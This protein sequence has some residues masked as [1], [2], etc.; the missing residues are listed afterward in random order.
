MGSVYASGSKGEAEGVSVYADGK[1]IWRGWTYPTLGYVHINIDKPVSAKAITIKM[2][3]NTKTQKATGD[4]AELAGGKADTFQ[5][6][7]TAKGK[8]ELRIVD[9]DFLYGMMENSTR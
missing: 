7:P 3:G 8:T 1:E 5:E 2:L 6:T 9:I 4:T